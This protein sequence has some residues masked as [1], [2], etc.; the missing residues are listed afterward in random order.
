MPLEG[1]SHG[2]KDISFS[3]GKHPITGDVVTLTNENAIARSVRN[4]VLTNL[5]ERFFNRDLGTN[6][7]SSLFENFDSITSN[8]I[9]E[10][11]RNVLDVYEE[12]VTLNEVKVTHDNDSSTLDCRI[13]YSIVGHAKELQ[14]LTFA[15]ESVR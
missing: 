10:R 6:I 11:I 3:F 5:N 7:R 9:E 2:F 4:L 13:L 14:E 8:I 12:R 1:N 15:I